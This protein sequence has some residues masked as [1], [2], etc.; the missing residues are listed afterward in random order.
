MLS[1]NLRVNFFGL[2]FSIL[3]DILV[4]FYVYGEGY[5]IFGILSYHSHLRSMFSQFFYEH[6]CIVS[7]EIVEYDR[8]IGWYLILQVASRVCSSSVDT[9]TVTMVSYLPI[10]LLKWFKADVTF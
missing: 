5:I 4:N 1:M 8:N 9:A 7:C 6:V 3:I 2:Q 10:V